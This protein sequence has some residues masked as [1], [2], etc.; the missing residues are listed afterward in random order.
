MN[1]QRFL[2]WW[3]AAAAGLLAFAASA[4]TGRAG[5]GGHGYGQH[6]MPA[7][8]FI[9]DDGKLRVRQFIVEADRRSVLEK[10]TKPGTGIGKR[11]TC[12]LD[13]KMI[14]SI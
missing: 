3:S 1:A 10:L 8:A 14:E 9:D 13:L 7:L 6:A 11:P 5:Y 12:G 2:V 4:P